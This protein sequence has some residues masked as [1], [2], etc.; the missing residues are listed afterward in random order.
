[1]SRDGR[2][3]GFHPS[4][5]V[6]LLLGSCVAAV[7]CGQAQDPPDYAGVVSFDSATIRVHTPSGVVRLRVELAQSREQQTMGLMERQSLAD[8]AGMLF[9]Y[10]RDQP[11]DA[12]FWMY[13]TRI[14]LDIAFLDSA[15]V[16]VATRQM[17]PCPATLASGCPSYAPGVPY[18]AALEVN[19]GAL[20]RH[21]IT[22]GSRVELLSPR[23]ISSP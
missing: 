9:L 13:R 18:R 5:R 20:A 2:P 15:G 16:V 23:A 1:M 8:S 4:A 3:K 22:L 11:A 17:E 21:G 6:V 10:E 14:S 12:G 19:A 7:A